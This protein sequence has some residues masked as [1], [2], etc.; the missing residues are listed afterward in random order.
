MI[1]K[2][3]RRD[4]R[5]NCW[6]QQLPAAGLPVLLG[7]GLG[8]LLAYL[9]ANGYWLLA[10]GIALLV[11]M[12]ILVVRYPFAAVMIW[13]VV[14][15]FVPFVGQYKLVYW[16][17]HRALPLIALVIILVSRALRLKEHRPMRLGPA[18]LAMAAFGIA[19][20][21]SILVFGD[22]IKS[23]LTLYDRTLV[24]FTIYLLVRFLN[25]REEDLRRLVPIALLVG[26]AECVIGL[27]SW[28]APQ[29][30]PS[31]WHSRAEIFGDRVT[32]TFTQ[33]EVY[34]SVLAFHMVLLFHGAMN[35]AGRLMRTALILVM[36]LEVVCIFF[37]FTRGCWLAGLL[38]LAGLL[39]LYPKPTLSLTL[40]VVA[41]AF[42][43]STG[44]LASEFAHAYER[45]K[46]DTTIQDRIVLANAGKRMF[47]ARPL[48]GW[49]YDNYDRYDWRFIERVGNAAP[50][51][52]DIQSGT[53]HNTYLTMLA[54]MG[55]IGLLLYSFPVLWWLCLTF[56]VLPRLPKEG[57]WSRR[58]LVILWL[59][60]GAYLVV[61]QSV[62][63]RFFLDPPTL[64]WFSLGLV[65]NLV[66]H[67]LEPESISVPTR[68][69][70]ARRTT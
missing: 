63:M 41:V 3:L 44:L 60:V 9:V 33:P 68:F 20:V 45:F 21:L 46:T 56:R 30:L 58:L 54:E 28:F 1:T 59:P 13:L 23:I 55:V 34:A 10:C 37:T 40:L 12:A 16:V 11:P 51:T 61:S 6:A 7:L 25:P 53:S 48:L 8:V 27:L 57:F 65:A 70:V 62:D 64:V 42:I 36:G 69:P 31:I 29:V 14:V 4:E 17:L 2:C 52:W 32:G 47:F 26:F 22:S 18:E 35:R 66:Q 67:Y 39:Y 38:V 49:G 43:V 5:R 15:P 50:T 19:A 24:P